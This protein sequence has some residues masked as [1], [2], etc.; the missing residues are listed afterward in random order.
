M[1]TYLA[2]L[3]IFIHVGLFLRLSQLDILSFSHKPYPQCINKDFHC[4]LKCSW[5]RKTLWTVQRFYDQSFQISNGFYTRF[6][7]QFILIKSHRCMNE[8]DRWTSLEANLAV[9]STQLHWWDE[10]TAPLRRSQPQCGATHRYARIHRQC[11]SWWQVTVCVQRSL[12][13]RLLELCSCAPSFSW[14]PFT[15]ICSIAA[16]NYL[17]ECPVNIL[18]S[19]RLLKINSPLLI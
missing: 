12:P 4:F 19:Y 14:L 11:W 17:S 5:D 9:V 15:T 10:G 1:N 13:P 2:I 6:N 8:Y 7:D 16:Q 3:Y 18:W